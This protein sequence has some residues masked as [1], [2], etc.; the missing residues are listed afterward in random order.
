MTCVMSEAAKI[1]RGIKVTSLEAIDEGADHEAYISLDES[2]ADRNAEDPFDIV[3]RNEDYPAIMDMEGVRGNLMVG[4]LWLQPERCKHVTRQ[5]VPS[6]QICACRVGRT[7][8]Q[9]HFTETNLS[10]QRRSRRC[11][12][13]SIDRSISPTYRVNKTSLSADS[14]NCKSLSSLIEAIRCSMSAFRLTQLLASVTRWSIKRINRLSS[15][16][17]A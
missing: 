13:R 11:S 6:T 7:R 15:N 1:K 2:L 4:V 9:F 8:N 14:A 17:P 3:R 10:H 5:S 12:L 16:L